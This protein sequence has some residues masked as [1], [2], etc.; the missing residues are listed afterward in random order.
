MLCDFRIKL[1]YHINRKMNWG[2]V[3]ETSV[4]EWDVAVELDFISCLLALWLINCHRNAGGKWGTRR[5]EG[6]VLAI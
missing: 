5:E 6:Y 3:M 2:M 4:G 1:I